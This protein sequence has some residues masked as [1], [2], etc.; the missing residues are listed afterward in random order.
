MPTDLF[1]MRINYERG[2]NQMR[3]NKKISKKIANIGKRKKKG[4]TCE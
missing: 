2:E 4:A 3:K 1:K